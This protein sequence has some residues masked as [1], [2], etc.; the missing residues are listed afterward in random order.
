M[1]TDREC[2]EDMG[3]FLNREA[4]IGINN[5]SY[6]MKVCEGQVSVYFYN[7]LADN[8]LIC[9]DGPIIIKI[10]RHQFYP[11]QKPI[12]VNYIGANSSSDEIF[13]LL[14]DPVAKAEYQKQLIMDS[15]NKDGMPGTKK[16]R[17]M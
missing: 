16:Q 12:R 6:I 2:L 8:S 13:Y 1:K 7:K 9:C 10:T 17:R 14:N 3:W 5:P 4:V 11:T 15:I